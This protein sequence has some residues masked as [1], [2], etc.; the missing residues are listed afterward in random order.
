M[1]VLSGLAAL[2]SI[3]LAGGMLAQAQ[4]ISMPDFSMPEISMP[5]AFD[6]RS[7]EDRY[8]ACEAKVK[9]MK[10]D[11]IGFE[12]RMGARFLDGALGFEGL[13]DAQEEHKQMQVKIKE[14][15]QRCWDLGYEL[16]TR[17]RPSPTPSPT[18]PYEVEPIG[19][20]HIP[21]TP[22]PRR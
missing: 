11:L 19:P 5:D 10:Q 20:Q 17:G 2:V 15:Q 3:V 8:W 12:E 14:Q 13:Y 16:A 1:R 22:P 18:L 6:G 7:L 9:E 4:G 21:L